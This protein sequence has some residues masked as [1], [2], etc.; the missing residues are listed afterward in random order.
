MSLVINSLLKLAENI[1]ILVGQNESGKST[2]LEGLYNALRIKSDSDLSRSYSKLKDEK[3][4]EIRVV[5]EI[6]ESDLRAIV[7]LA[8]LSP[9]VNDKYLINQK[10]VFEWK[11]H[12]SDETKI[13]YSK[14]DGLRDHYGDNLRY[15]SLMEQLTN[16]VDQSV[17]LLRINDVIF[18]SEPFIEPSNLVL[19]NKNDY[20]LNHVYLLKKTE[21]HH[22]TNLQND[23]KMFFKNTDF[24]I[25]EKGSRLEVVIVKYFQA[26]K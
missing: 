12:D 17:I 14:W 13:V 26:E 19:G 24:D 21:G 11:G 3:K 18:D 1:T 10:F 9:Q 23:V 8:G 2:I 22:F 4:F 25:I 6:N 15:D 20:P 16:Y 5:L 7:G